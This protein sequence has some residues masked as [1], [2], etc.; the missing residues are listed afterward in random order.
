ME[1]KI[2][3]GNWGSVRLIDFMGS[4][5]RIANAA[6]ASFN[7]E[8]ET[9]D[10]RDEKLIK[11]LATSEPSHTMP[12]RHVYFT[13]Q[14]KAP[15]F[16]LRQWQKH[17]IGCEWSFEQYK[18][19]PWSEQS[20]RYVAY[21]GYWMPDYFRM[22]AEN[23]KQGSIDEPHP[24]TKL[25][26]EKYKEHSEHALELYDLMVDD[27]VAPEQARTILGMNMFTNFYWTASLQAVAHFVNL[28]D[29]PEAQPEIKNFARIISEM[30]DDVA[31]YA[32]S[33]R[34]SL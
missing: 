2:K 16:V 3:E 32:W 8:K 22:R 34:K 9:L 14:V 12:F 24:N 6:R 29:H 26:L 7:K 28:R 23:K 33:F 11:F 4:D 19:M 10:Q 30:I 1:L 21:D 20:G 13:F 15:I 27:G 17:L 18:D 5:L 31:P 25:W